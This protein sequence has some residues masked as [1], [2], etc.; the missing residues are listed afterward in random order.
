M[1]Y[2]VLSCLVIFLTM[3]SQIV[4]RLQLQNGLPNISITNVNF[5]LSLITNFWLLS[6]IIA[7][8]LS[9]FCWSLVLTHN[10]NVT[11]IYPIVTSS[12]ILLVSLGNF[13]IFHDNIHSVNVL[14]GMFI[15]LGIFLLLR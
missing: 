3:Y 5:Y 6:A 7:F 8:I 2:I 11:K 4:L 1:N 14:G 15:L 12:T 10:V 9:F 13:L